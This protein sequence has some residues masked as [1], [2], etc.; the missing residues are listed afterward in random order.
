MGRRPSPALVTVLAL[1]AGGILLLQG[2]IVAPAPAPSGRTARAAKP[3]EDP[4]GAPSA[5][6]E[7][8]TAEEG[9]L[10]ITPGPDGK[11][12][13]A[14]VDRMM[15]QQVR[16]AQELKAEGARKTTDRVQLNTTQPPPQAPPLAGA[17]PSPAAQ[18]KAPA[19]GG[20]TPQAAPAAIPDTNA[21]LSAL[22]GA[23]PDPTKPTGGVLGVGEPVAVGDPNAPKF[24]P[25][26]APADERLNAAAD[27]LARALRDRAAASR[28]PAAEFAALAWLDTIRP[29]VLGSLE[30]GPAAKALD[31]RQTRSLTLARDMA[32]RQRQDP[33]L[34]NDPERLWKAMTEVAQPITQAKD[35][36]ISTAELCT[37]V[38][39][40][41]QYEPVKDRALLAGVPHSIIVYAEVDGYNL[42][43]TAEA[44]GEPYTVDMGQ[45]VEVW[46]DADRPT[47]QRRW[48]ET[49]I[50]DVSRRIR[51]DFYITSVIELPPNLSVGAYNLKIIVKDRLRNAQAEKTI[52]FT[53]IADGAIVAS[54]G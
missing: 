13:Q 6:L 48:S 18:A 53:I 10:P 52:P 15:A 24:A 17:Q 46:Q 5:G 36:R 49:S 50:K 4:E 7:R 20:P 22:T 45:A 35:V 51:R 32:A 31:P 19:V 54:G 28:A 21:G 25:A 8:L 39:G 23:A 1:A 30:T 44:D 11:Y 40:F 26:T 14:D 12:S 42:R 33:A 47:L 29:G 38:D 9:T 41:G 2:C 16:L 43:K 37:R 3:A 27:E 34:F